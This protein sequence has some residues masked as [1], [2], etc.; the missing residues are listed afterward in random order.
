MLDYPD[1]DIEPFELAD[2]RSRL[3]GGCCQL[4]ELLSS[5]ERGR[6][7]REGV[8]AAIIGRPNAGKSSLLNAILGYDRAIVTAQ[9]GT[10]RDTIEE[11]A[12]LGGVLLR[13]T[14]TAGLREAADEAEQEGV[15]RALTAAESAELVL[16]VFDGSEPLRAE[17]RETIEAAKRAK[18]AV[19]IMN[20]SDLPR[21]ADA[22]EPEGFDAVVSLSA[23]TGEGLDALAE[24]VARLFP[25][26][27]KP[28][29]EILT[30][31]R[32]AEAMNR[33]L[34]SLESAL[35]AMDEGLTP[36]AVLTEA[37]Y[38][39]DALSELTGRSVK[40]DVTER[41]FSRFCVGK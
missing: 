7:L 14:D 38:A 5:F 17:D 25:E 9:P 28:A 30:N 35:R 23:R 21:A 2:Y 6:V 16:A 11:K 13:L 10:T 15:R 27:E 1:E 19:C 12:L 32:Q 4:R 40:A 29:G 37:E 36:D 8:S 22:A 26:P 41:I 18:R 31:A 33:A 24:A 20:K 34:G 39:L 3:E